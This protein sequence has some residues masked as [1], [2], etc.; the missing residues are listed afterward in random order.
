MQRSM[1]V[2]VVVA[3]LLRCGLFGSPPTRRSGPSGNA[4]EGGQTSRNFT[5]S[6]SEDEPR[7]SSC[8]NY[9][10]GN[11]AQR[12]ET[13]GDAVCEPATASDMIDHDTAFGLSGG[14]VADWSSC[15]LPE[16]PKA[17]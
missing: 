9:V 14:R 10:R 4:E 1:R 8:P 11:P 7:E 2:A 16:L 3:I 15:G 13:L 12:G 5:N 17:K 6:S